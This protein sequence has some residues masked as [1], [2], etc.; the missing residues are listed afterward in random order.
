MMNWGRLKLEFHHF[1][2]WNSILIDSVFKCNC[3]SHVLLDEH[4]KKTRVPL[5]NEFQMHTNE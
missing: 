5:R 1:D 3:Q 4:G 2:I